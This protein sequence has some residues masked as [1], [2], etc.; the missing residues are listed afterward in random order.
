MNENKAKMSVIIPVYN[1]EPYLRETLTSV[2]AQSLKEIEIICVDDGSTDRS[3]QIIKEYAHADER[4]KVIIQENQGPSQARNTGMKHA[5]GRYVYFLDS[6][7][8][9]VPTA[10][11]TMYDTMEKEELDIVTFDGETF[12]DDD[13]KGDYVK[14]ISYK[15][16]LTS[17]KKQKG[18]K[19][20][21]AFFFNHE[22]SASVCLMA[23]RR[24]FLEE[25]KMAFYPG[26]FHEDNLF[27]FQCMMEARNC[28][29]LHQALFLRR[30]RKNSIMTQKVSE[31]HFLGYW[32]CYLE[33]LTYAASSSHGK[34]QR[35][36]INEY[37]N[38]MLEYAYEAF[39]KLTVVQ[40]KTINWEH[41][42]FAKELYFSSIGRPLSVKEKKSGLAEMMLNQ[43]G[44]E[45]DQLK[46]IL[47]SPSYRLGTGMTFLGRKARTFLKIIKKNGL[48]GI[49]YTLKRKK[50]HI[51]ESATMVVPK[52]KAHSIETEKNLQKEEKAIMLLQ[53]EIKQQPY[54]IQ[55]PLV[56][57]ILP[58]K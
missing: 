52:T 26:I 3:L 29:H 39:G 1:V 33:G 40:R 11:Q 53:E 5:K 14:A 16:P 17:A 23:L 57:V 41:F 37:A 35:L 24:R 28:K 49:F 44:S 9:I 21:R 32:I 4:V 42:P 19:L 34:R 18:W 50:K 8:T 27:T 58:A 48:E 22:Y 20:L 25:K 36:V 38:R 45:Q 13:T 55:E 51:K 56:S 47:Q 6:D 2:L 54:C 7:D 15:R 43:S 10:L 31:K 12:F 46:G 30:M